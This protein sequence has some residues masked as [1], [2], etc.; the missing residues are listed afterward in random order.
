MAAITRPLGRPLHLGLIIRINKV[1]HTIS[2]LRSLP[3]VSSRHRYKAILVVVH[4]PKPGLLNFGNPFDYH[5][6]RLFMCTYY[7][8]D[9]NV[10]KKIFKSLAI[11]RPSFKF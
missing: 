10:I 9:I 11:V 2:S 5:R 7:S 3:R 1:L 8:R 4:E 6:G